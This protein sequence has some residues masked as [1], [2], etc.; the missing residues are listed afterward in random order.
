MKNQIK[1]FLIALVLLSAL[2]VQ[3]STCFA[4]GTAFTYQGRL[5][6]NGSPATGI[7]DLQ[8]ALYDASN[9]P[10]TLVAGPL[11]NSP[12][13]VTNGLFTVQLDFGGVFD[14]NARWLDIGVRTNGSAGG[15]TPLSARREILPAPYA[16]F[17]GTASNVSGTVSAANLSG[18][19]SLAQLPATVVTNGASG[20]NISG[21]FS[22]NGA[23]VTN[24]NLFVNSLG[25][26]TPPV[27][28]N[29]TLSSSPGVGTQPHTVTAADVNGDGKM[30]L[31][32]ANY[33][34]NSLTVLTN[35]GSG[36]FVISSSPGGGAHPVP[37]TA[38]DVNGDGKM[39][40]ISGNYNAN[41]LTVLTNDGS[42]GF[43][44]SSSPGVGTRPVS[45]TAADVNGDG[46][47]DLISANEIAYTLT[48]LT[49]D[50]SGGFVISS[51]PGV[52]S[53][54]ESV[55]AADVNGDGKMDLISANYGPNTL[56][57][58]TNDGSGGFVISSSPGVGSHPESVTA[59]DVNGDGKMDLISANSSANTL[60]V[61]TNN[62]SGGFV[63]A[64]SPGVGIYPLSVTAA[65]V[66][67]DGKMDLISANHNA[68]TLTVLTNNGSGGFAIASSPGV[69]GY[70]SFVTAADVNGDG[71]M[72]LISANDSVSTLT[73]L[74]NTLVSA[75]FQGSFAGN[76]AGLTSLNAASV[77]SGTID[78]AR[79][80]PE[81]WT[82]GG[83][84]GVFETGQAT[85]HGSLTVE[86]NLTITF[87]TPFSSPPKIL[88]SAANDPGY[89]DVNDTFSVSVSSNS[90]SAF[91][92]NIIR[93]DAATGWDQQLRINWQAWQ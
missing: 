21:T 71:K 91:Q 73:V 12:V 46:K 79:L 60:T 3:I 76:G 5:L 93:E 83:S 17:A 13:G 57:V 78:D 69:D 88:V 11:T 61:L 1:Q 80:S 74:T 63:I 56:T 82:S 34:D 2:N 26:I 20:V 31:I 41:T 28:G 23:G 25:A 75:A 24:V 77:A 10:S 9:N 62:G 32:S 30:D 86:T 22:G 64:S 70:P 72:D 36:G 40:L 53:A 37:V 55:A 7:Y 87:P 52:G 85:N 44:I 67:G 84:P 14:G 19:I 43:V 45:V 27:W 35:D 39:D 16:M 42:G 68:S 51:S 92:V 66:N 15:F 49:N 54:P 59:A 47:M 48:V 6:D 38:A 18:T 4:Q 65:D 33:L 50:G 58:L 90:V 8:F 89:P 81:V 29:F